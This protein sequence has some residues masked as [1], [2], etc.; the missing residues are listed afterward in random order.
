MKEMGRAA[1]ELERDDGRAM[2]READSKPQLLL[3]LAV[4]SKAN[5]TAFKTWQESKI[6]FAFDTE[7]TGLI[8]NQTVKLD[9]LP[10]V[11]EFYGCLFD[12][13]TG[14]VFDEADW[15]I[16]P[17]GSLNLE[18][19][20]LTTITPDMVEDKPNFAFYAH[21]IKLM[22]EQSELII[23]HNLSFDK[24][25]IDVEMRRLGMSV[26]W[27]RGL[28]TVEQTVH[29]KGFRLSLGALHEYLFGE[30]FAGAH[31]AKVDV[32]ATM[33]C[34]VELYKRGEL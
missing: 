16:K 20:G 22:L 2:E 1:K 25:M 15:L 7:T 28:C 17:K 14:W 11:I 23:G 9:K 31:R 6:A 12:L 10:E 3:P 33:R 18:E 24:E 21:D 8:E 13:E 34:A 5:I 4:E 19:T 26:N 27:P 29:L 32:M 30:T